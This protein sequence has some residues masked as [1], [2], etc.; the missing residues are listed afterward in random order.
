[1]QPKRFTLAVVALSGWVLGPAC[2]AI[3]GIEDRVEAPGFD[4]ASEPPSTP[5]VDDSGIVEKD[6]D[7]CAANPSSCLDPD[8]APPKGCPTGCLPPAPA[9]WKGPSATYDG[10]ESTKPTA[11]PTA[12]SKSELETHQGMT[13]AAATCACGAPVVTG[14]KCTASVVAYADLCLNVGTKLGTADSSLGQCFV[15]AGGGGAADYKVATPILV[16]GTCTYPNA[17]TTKPAPSFQKVE[18][19]CSQPQIAE[20]AGRPECITTPAPDQPFGR[21]C[22]HKEGEHACPAA[23]YAVRFVAYKTIDDTRACTACTATPT[24]GACGAKWGQRFKQQDCSGMTLFP[25]DKDANACID[26]YADGIL[27]DIR[28]MGPTTGGDCGASGGTASGTAS[29]IE[30]VTFCCNQ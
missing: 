29:S 12:Y 24:G 18:V 4:A 22:I 25:N 1:M 23:D 11:C 21:L 19:V 10:A 7:P 20:C 2:Q 27:I 8:A 26:G 30:P 28:G 9:D 6:G 14:R 16:P 15:T 13:A 17:N 3:V 5:V